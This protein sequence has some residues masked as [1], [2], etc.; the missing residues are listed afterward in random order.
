M[1]ETIVFVYLGLALFISV[2]RENLDPVF[3]IAAIVRF[4]LGFK[5]NST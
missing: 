5:L 2:N 1:T 4:Q 3:I